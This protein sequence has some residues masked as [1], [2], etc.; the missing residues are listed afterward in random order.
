MEL[1]SLKAVSNSGF[2]RRG[3]TSAV[4]KTDSKT[5][6]ANEIFAMCATIGAK[7]AEHCLSNNVGRISRGDDLLEGCMIA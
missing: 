3:N 1:L 2:F 6:S 5:L 7:T 4:L